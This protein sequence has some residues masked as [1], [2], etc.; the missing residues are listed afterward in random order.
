GHKDK[1]FVVRTNPFRTDKL[2]T[3]GIKHIK[4]WQ[5]SG[6]SALPPVPSPC[7]GRRGA[8]PLHRPPVQCRFSCPLACSRFSSPCPVRPASSPCPLP[9]PPPSSPISS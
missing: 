6:A 2:V 9:P 8:G 7:P 3:V 1:I 5:H 4:F